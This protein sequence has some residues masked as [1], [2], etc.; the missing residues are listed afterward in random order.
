MGH[1]NLGNPNKIIDHPVEL[2]ISVSQIVKP[3]ITSTSKGNDKGR[4]SIGV[5]KEK[6]SF[7]GK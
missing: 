4:K 3:N 5:S 2:E 6:K 1:T 7:I